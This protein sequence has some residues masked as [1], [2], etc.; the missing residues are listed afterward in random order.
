[1]PICS[2][3]NLEM[4]FQLNRTRFFPV[5]TLKKKNTYC[6]LDVLAHEC[7]FNI[8]YLKKTKPRASCT[9]THS[10]NTDEYLIFRVEFSKKFSNIVGSCD[11]WFFFSFF[12]YLAEQTVPLSKFEEWS[13]HH[14]SMLISR[15]EALIIQSCCIINNFP[16]SFSSFAHLAFALC[17]KPKPKAE[18]RRFALRL[19]T[20]QPICLF[21]SLSNGDMMFGFVD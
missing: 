1:M 4:I 9:L 2:V 10:Q 16:L 13:H 7:L 19:N 15:K 3:T 21:R 14:I 12:S 20:E 8:K 17:M 18:R 6:Q 5:V 11:P